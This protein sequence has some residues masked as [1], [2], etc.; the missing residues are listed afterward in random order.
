MTPFNSPGH[1]QPTAVASGKSSLRSSASAFRSVA[2]GGVTPMNNSVGQCSGGGARPQKQRPA[3]QCSSSS[4]RRSSYSPRSVVSKSPYASPQ[5]RQQ[6]RPTTPRTPR[7]GQNSI[8]GIG[9]GA[10]A[11]PSPSKKYKTEMCNNVSI[12]FYTVSFLCTNYLISHELLPL[13]F[14]FLDVDKWLV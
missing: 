6:Q 14:V 7:G 12:S 1:Q 4:N 13:T 8:V 10:G 9:G 5:D 11:S 2:A 3:P